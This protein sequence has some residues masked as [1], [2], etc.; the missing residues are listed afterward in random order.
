MATCGSYEFVKE[1][2][3]TVLRVDCEECTFFPSIED[4]PTV[5]EI[6]LRAL[7]K[8]GTATKI[9]L[10]QK[11]D[12]EYDYETTIMLVELARIYRH[13]DK[14]RAEHEATE[15]LHARRITSPRYALFRNITV[16]LVL[17]D[18]LGAYVELKRISRDEQRLIEQNVVT[19]EDL[20]LLRIYYGLL[21][22]TI[23][24]FEQT[25]IVKKAQPFLPGYK[26]G[27]RIVYRQLFVPTV[28]PDFMFTK[29]M[30]SYPTGADEIDSYEIKDK[31]TGEKTG[32]DVTIFKLPDSVQLL[33]HVLPPEFKLTTD[34]YD[35]LDQ[36]KK[37]FEA[38]QP[39]RNEFLDPARLRE[40]FSNLG[41]DL[42]LE[43]AEQKG[44][45]LTKKDTDMLTKILL[46]Y[47]IGFG[48][49]EVLL[50]DEQVQDITINSP[51]G[52]TPVFIV[53]NKYDD[54]VTNIYPTITEANSWASK[55]R[56]ISGRPLDE[57][58]PIL[59]TELIIPGARAR[60]A[61]IYEPL[62][63]TGLA[64]ALRRHRDDP[65]TLARFVSV[66]M[67]SPLAAGI[68]SFLI[69]GNRTILVAG[70]RSSGKT[71]LLGAVMVELM[72]NRR[73]ITIE[74][75]VTGDSRII[76]ERNGKLE[77]T[78]V[79]EIIDELIKKQG[80]KNF[81]GREFVKPKEKLRVYSINK[82]G[83]VIL[84]TV[85]Q[86]MR[87]KVTKPIYQIITSTGRKLNLTGDHSLFTLGMNNLLQPVR[88]TDLKQGD[89]VVT[90]R[91][92]PNNQKSLTQI[93]LTTK[94]LPGTY[95]CGQRIKD[96][97]TP[98]WKK[99]QVIARQ[100][101]YSKA[102]PSAWKRN[103]VLPFEVFEKLSLNIDGT[104][105]FIKKSASS[106]KIPAI[107]SITPELLTL[108]GLW[109]ADGSYDK[110]SI[111]I[112]V[113]DE[114]ERN[115][116]RTL[117]QQLGLTTK[118]HSDGI[119]LMIN[120]GVLKDVFVSVFEL[121]G[122]AY[123]KKIPSWVYGL[124]KQQIAF[125]LRGI[126]SGD[127]CV[128]DKEIVMCLASREL[129][130][131]IQT[132]LL[133]FGVIMRTT[134]HQRPD[135]TFNLRVSSLASLNIFKE[136]IGLLQQYKNER[137]AGLCAKQSTHDSTDIIPFPETAKIA[138]V[139]QLELNHHDYITRNFSIGRQKFTRT[140]YGA[141]VINNFYNTLAESDIL[142]DK[143]VSIQQIKTEET[144]VY[145]FSVPKHENFIC[146]NILAH[147]TLELP[148]QALRKLNYN[149]QSMKVASAL[150]R[151]T[152]EVSADEGIRTT[153]R[154]GDSA[155]IV[156]EVR[157]TEAKA[158][159]EAMRVGAL[160]NIVAGTIHGDSPYGVFD[161]VVNDLNVPRTSFKATDIIIVANRVRSA[162]G[163]KSFRKLTQIT[164]VRKHWEDDPVRE[165]GFVDLLKY[166]T[167]TELAEPTKDLLSGD[168]EVLKSIAGMIKQF[169]GNWDA[170][171]DNIKLRAALKQELVDAAKTTNTQSILEA[172]FVINANDEFHRIT[173]QIQEE[174]GNVDTEKIYRQWKEWLRLAVK[175]EV[176]KT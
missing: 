55:L 31:I 65:W 57:A 99:I 176:T 73:I 70:T 95:F 125:V 124:S 21:N 120:S 52:K 72:R 126:F 4:N 23:T 170:V 172:P 114:N 159:Y 96:V 59:D 112:S 37:K 91:I 75:S 61:A 116:V 135:K 64:F 104:N 111:I 154:L 101:S 130:H 67:M 117:S 129:V 133:Q 1:G 46:R 149:I 83:K 60:L 86:C 33:Y 87:H 25:N 35:I 85:S 36:A 131:D 38:H 82:E 165:N 66:G 76:V 168:S 49:V 20:A 8:E 69:D 175:K 113:V 79:G 26:L 24:M 6:I 77:K 164:E 118:M 30:S 71:S 148:I 139:Q 58:N 128:S 13:I 106:T 144:Y 105:I 155:L 3:D 127:G 156:G 160:A 27:D 40:T 145:D 45:T 152:Q 54:C 97:I 88:T 138:A 171:W 32:I 28:R 119:S 146:E 90:P 51:V 174:T 43:L 137:L 102:M 136:S 17:R 147:N 169:A 62:N 56:L 107:I 161:R 92:T 103:C 39:T 173:E 63:P 29:L 11:R 158:L 74:D 22:D 166:D 98:N 42:L 68:I 48:L 150:T 122:N 89:Y 93:D 15:P 163:L 7:A 47:T 142:W 9:I 19:Q 151:G 84:A 2:E 94:R 141:D 78:T 115:I 110:N 41:T 34:L 162:D 134:Q 81:D 18:P 143:I 140:L 53:H 14:Q 12:Y 167:R 108:T 109:L 123:T 157:S 50:Q 153:Q 100:L 121:Q 16:R 44:I 10:T 5:M 80:G 132:L